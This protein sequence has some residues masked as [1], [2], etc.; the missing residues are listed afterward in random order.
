[1]TTKARLFVVG[2]GLL[3]VAEPALAHHSFAAEFDEKQPIRLVGTLTKMD[4]VNPHGWLYIDVTGP[5]GKMVT[6]AIEAGSPNSLLRRGLRKENFPIGSKVVVEGFRAKSGK[7]AAN[8][9]TVTFPDGTNFFLGSSGSGAPND[10]AE[11]SQ[12]P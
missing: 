9:R 7:P 5:D 2:V 12:K 1:M 8:G 4:W 10:G 6:W 3:L 11:R